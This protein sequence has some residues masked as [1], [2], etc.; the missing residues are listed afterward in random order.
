MAAGAFDLWRFRLPA[1]YRLGTH[2]HDLTGFVVCI[3]GE[4]RATVSGRCHRLR[5]GDVMVIPKGVEHEEY[6]PLSTD[7]LIVSLHGEGPA[8]DRLRPMLHG[9]TVQPAVVSYAH[10]HR[11]WFELIAADDLSPAEAEDATVDIVHE[12]L[13]TD[14]GRV[15]AG[16][17]WLDRAEQRLRHHF[18]EANAVS[19]TADAFGVSAEH[20]VRAFRGRFGITPGRFVRQRRVMVATRALAE[21]DAPIA[22]VAQQAGFSDQSHLTRLFQLQFRTTPYRYRRGQRRSSG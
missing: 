2:I 4:Y 9:F 19:R 7:C 16:L 14:A 20:F 11:L 8:Q 6:A 12:W 10:L 13:H 3:D 15:A 18:A 17:P 22:Q 21:S 5:P 1:G